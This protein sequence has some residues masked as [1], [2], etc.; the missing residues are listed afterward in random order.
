MSQSRDL[1]M[2][3]AATTLNLLKGLGFVLNY[4][5]S[6]LE[7]SQV[8]EFLVFEINSQTLTILLP[9]DEVRNIQK[10]LSQSIRQPK[11]ISSRIIKVPGA[12]NFFHSGIFSGPSS[13]SQ[14]SRR[15]KP[16][17]ETVSVLRDY[18]KSQ[19]S[20]STGDSMVGDHLIAWNGRAILRQ[21]I[22]L[23]IET[24][25]STKGWGAQCQG[26]STGGR[27]SPKKKELHINSLKLLA[28]SLAVK[29][30]AKEEGKVHILLLMDSVS[31]VPYINKLGGPH[32]FVLKAWPT[33]NRHG[34][35]LLFCLRLM[36]KKLVHIHSFPKF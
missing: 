31:A 11:P 18:C 29:R 7:T 23:T 22:Q 13:L 6:C 24:D 14:P 26:A 1:A 34:T 3:H 25:A 5:K 30:F 12:P 4:E 10:E 27:W 20:S 19:L 28:G 32:C 9:R 21:P 17:V 36:P 2:T 16:S 8:K 15:Q 33:T 35:Y